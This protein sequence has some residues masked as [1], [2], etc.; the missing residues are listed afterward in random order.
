MHSTVCT[1][2]ERDYHYGVAALTNSL[3]SSGFKG[4]VWAGYRGALPLWANP[5]HVTPRYEEYVVSKECSI[6]FIQV[7]PPH[8]MAHYKPLLIDGILKDNP[9]YDAIAYF[10][11][12]IVVNWTWSAYEEWMKCGVALCEDSGSPFSINHPMRF[13][14]RK[15]CLRHGL[16]PRNTFDTYINS[17]FIGVTRA[18]R[19]ILSDWNKAVECIGNDIPGS[20]TEVWHSGWTHPFCFPDQDGLNAVLM[21]TELPLSI[22]N[23]SGMSFARGHCAMSHAIGPY[24]P[25]RKNILRTAIRG[26][27]PSTADKNFVTHANGAIRTFSPLAMTR[28]RLSVKMG[29]LICRFMQKP[30]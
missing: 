16:S 23:K 22:L 28:L 6:R 13:A 25:W 19:S 10:D 9:D 11:P 20:L 8:H 17:G 27:S 29:A 4:V 14:W 7:N 12:D 30:G 24:K 15:F 18:H 26:F 3:I 2:F 5:R 1:L 21:C